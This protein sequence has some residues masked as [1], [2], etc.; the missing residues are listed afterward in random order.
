MWYVKLAGGH[1]FYFMTKVLFHD[2]EV[3]FNSRIN[4]EDLLN[5]KAKLNAASGDIF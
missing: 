4:T 2:M 5:A 1:L 3:L